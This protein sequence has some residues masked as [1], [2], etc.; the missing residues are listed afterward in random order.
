MMELTIRT[1]KTED[2]DKLLV[3]YKHMHDR[4]TPAPSDT[5]LDTVWRDIVTDPKISV[6]IGEID[7]GAVSSC[8]SHHRTEP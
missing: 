6:F 5:I 3:L 4:D 7:G 8:K 1:C 2:L